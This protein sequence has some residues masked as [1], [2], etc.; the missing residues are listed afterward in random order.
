MTKRLATFDDWVSYFHDWQA[1]IGFDTALLGDFKLETKF[2][3]LE[4]EKIEFGDYK[5]NAKW[6]STLQIPQQQIR[7]A[8]LNLIVFQADT[9]F[10]S[11]EQQRHLLKTA[12]SDYD[13]KSAVRIMGEEMRH[14]W[15]MCYLLMNHFGET[16][17]IEAA[18][19]LE[20]RA[21]K[22]ERLLG[23][24]NEPVNHW[25][26]FFVYTQFVDRD[27]KYQLKMLSRSGFA[28]LAQSMGPMLKEEAFHLGTG[29]QGITRVVKAGKIPTPLLQKYLNK[30]VPTAFDLFGT[31]NSGSAH[32]AYVWGIKGRYNE[33]EA[34]EEAKKDELNDT[35]RRL[36]RQ[37][38]VELMEKINAL[39]K[40]GERRLSIPDIKFHRKI[41]RHK[42]ETW[43]VTGERLSEKE[44]EQHLMEVLPSDEDER[45][46][47]EIFKSDDWIAPK[48][49]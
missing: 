1:D 28:P 33:T 29:N 18:K 7:D 25:L 39:V 26:D 35:A 21:Y 19:Q 15:Q 20:R 31:D 40:P 3:D 44:Y 36:Y 46:L 9:E 17:K 13:L 24:F 30:W 48:G 45:K 41:G 6:T 42:T 12:P 10:A 2:A 8:L 14:G 34:A 16:G 4:S 43:S 38:I 27:G 22:N 5:G 37:E 23:S 47:A 11:V 49:G 32:W